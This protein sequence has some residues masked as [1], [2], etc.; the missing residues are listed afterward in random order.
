MRCFPGIA[1]GEGVIEQD[2]CAFFLQGSFPVISLRAFHSFCVGE[3][4]CCRCRQCFGGDFTLTPFNTTPYLWSWS[5]SWSCSRYLAGLLEC[6]RQGLGSLIISAEVSVV[7]DVFCIWCLMLGSLILSA[8]APAVGICCFLV[9]SFM[10]VRIASLTNLRRLT[11]SER[12]ISGI[13]FFD[14]FLI[15]W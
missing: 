14:I 12:L 4:I 11:I 8:A 9:R 15:F 10:H 6:C 13:C 7:G 3:W 5:W 2:Q 1:S